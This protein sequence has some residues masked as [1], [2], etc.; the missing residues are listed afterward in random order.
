MPT[1][2]PGSQFA[3]RD[4]AGQFA[5]GGGKLRLRLSEP[6]AHV[7]GGGRAKQA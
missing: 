2:C 4:R 3:V 7:R 6:L 5:P 1:Q